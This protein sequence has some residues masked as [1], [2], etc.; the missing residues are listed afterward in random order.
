MNQDKETKV[1]VIIPC[2]NHG[3]YV[4][5]AVKSVLN[6]TYSN[7]EIIVVNDGSTDEYTNKL[8]DNYKRPKT[9]VLKTENRGLSM[10][11]NAG[12]EI[13][14]GEYILPLDADDKIHKTFLEKT[15]PVLENN[16]DINIVACK[17]KY[18]GCTNKIIPLPKYKFPDIILAGQFQVTSLFRKSDWEKVGGFKRNLRYGNEDHDFWLS[19]IERGG[20]VYQIPEILFFYRKLR[21][22]MSSSTFTPRKETYNFLTIYKN[23]RELYK[24]NVPTLLKQIMRYKYKNLKKNDIIRKL[25]YLS[26]SGYVLSL[27][28]FC[29]ILHLLLK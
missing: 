19:I 5:E 21:T 17:A 10:A 7:F 24:S 12:I 27:I 11:R 23:H 8:L 18:F 4:D 2:Y 20:K 1:S 9:T 28:M 22:S 6:Q 29:L 14:K 13:A 16:K 15:V 3:K 25:A 26:I